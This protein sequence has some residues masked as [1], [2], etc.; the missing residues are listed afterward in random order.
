MDPAI[1][2]APLTDAEIDELDHFLLYETDVDDSMTLDMLDGYLHALAVGPTT[3]HPTQWMP[4]IWG[5]D[6]TGMMPP[7]KGIDQVNRILSLVTRLYNSIVANL[8]DP[9]GPMIVPLWSTFQDGDRECDDAEIWA[10][11]FI[12]GMD[13]CK[14]DWAPLLENEQGRA[15][16]RPIQ[17]LGEDDFGPERDA[18]TRTPE[19]REKLSLQIPD[20]VLAMHQY[21]LPHRHAVYERQV[22]RSMGSKVG[23]N[24]PCPCGS[25]KKF[26]KCCG[27]VAELH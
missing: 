6:F 7:M 1:V 25:G 24:D 21:W 2:N 27:A 23:R 18:L 15:W 19:D 5:E 17:L 11:G 20:A 10:Y 16:L 4:R 3:V 8:E 12:A 13:L 26:K 9:D 22:A 14:E